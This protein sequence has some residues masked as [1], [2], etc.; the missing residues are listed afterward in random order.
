MLTPQADPSSGFAFVRDDTA[1][2]RMKNP[3]NTKAPE[4]ASVT[5][6]LPM[7]VGGVRYAHRH[8]TDDC[9]DYFAAITF[10]S[11]RHLVE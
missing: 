11:S 4:G 1:F 8:P 7:R 10:T 3:R 5:M 9:G 2:L 6:P